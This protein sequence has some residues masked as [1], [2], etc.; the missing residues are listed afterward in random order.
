MKLDGLQMP[1]MVE[2]EKDTLTDTF[3]RFILE[4]LERGFGVTVGHALRRVLVSAVQGAAI[5]RINIEG[6]QH[7]FSA[8]D[9]VREDVPEV[10][11]N[12]KEVAIR[13]HGDEDR[14]LHIEVE[15]PCDLLAKDLATDPSVEITNP[16]LHIATLGDGAKVSMDLTVGKGRGYVFARFVMRLVAASKLL[17]LRLGSRLRRSQGSVGWLGD[18]FTAARLRRFSR[19]HRGVATSSRDL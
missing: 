17:R 8:I 2:I 1:R 19:G 5:K 9:G 3:G 6:V 11:L 16:D 13:Y 15:G 14:I 10:V 4:P 12:L 18:G 7:E